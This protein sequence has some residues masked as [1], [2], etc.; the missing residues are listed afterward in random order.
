MTIP[1][2]IRTTVDAKVRAHPPITRLSIEVALADCYRVG[3]DDLP[4]V[5][6]DEFHYMCSELNAHYARL[7]LL[8]D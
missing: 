3:D 2:T 5:D 1:S 7:G 6:D 4:T 8:E